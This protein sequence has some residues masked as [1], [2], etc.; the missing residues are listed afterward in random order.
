MNQDGTTTS[1]VTSGSPSV[2]GQSVTFTATVTPNSP[3][4]GTPSG[5]VQFKIDGADFCSP[6]TLS[7][8]NATSGSTTTPAVGG[9]AIT[10]AHSGDGNFS[11]S[12][13]T[14]TEVVSQDHA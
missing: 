3:G 13:G 2:F 4:S 14:L 11:S 6:A 8:G 9:R 12:P 7:G 1:V 5:T 10:A